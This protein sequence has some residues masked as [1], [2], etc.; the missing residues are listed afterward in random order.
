MA[1]LTPRDGAGGAP[2]PRSNQTLVM[3]L[4]AGGVC[5][6]LCAGVGLLA[7]LLFP[8]L[9][10]VR[11]KARYAHGTN[12]LK[13]IGLAFHAFHDVHGHLPPLDVSLAGEREPALSWPAALLPPLGRSDL[14]DGIDRS[15]PWDAPE[16][17]DVYQTP[18]PVFLM[19]VYEQVEDRQGYALTH[20]AANARVVGVEPPLK[21]GDITDGLSTTMLAGQVADGFTPWGDPECVRDPADGF[22]GGPHQFGGPGGMLLVL[23]LDGSV[24]TVNA[25]AIAPQILRAIATPAEGEPPADL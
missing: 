3:L 18:L 11:E 8:A 4:V 15:K 16:N 25:D 19:P 14:F 9:L 22:G 24:R 23:M 10:S 5:L 20:F 1:R 7:T 12:N 13:E 17:A 21:L 6:L 2:Q